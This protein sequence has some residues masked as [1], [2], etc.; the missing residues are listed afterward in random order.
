MIVIWIGRVMESH[1]VIE[2]DN[3]VK[4]KMTVSV[5]DWQSG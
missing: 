2:I 4:I 3:Q 1:C 5:S